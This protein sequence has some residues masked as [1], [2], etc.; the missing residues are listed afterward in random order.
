MALDV[1]PYH[2]MKVLVIEDLAEMRSSMKS[3]LGNMGVADI[4][5][6]NNGE[7]AL[8]KMGKEHYDIVFSDYELGRGKDGQQILED[9]GFSREVNE[10]NAS[11]GFVSENG[12]GVT[13]WTRNLFDEER[14]TTAFPGVAQAGSFNGYPSVPRTYG[15]SVRKQF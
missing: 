3:M 2:K 13:L 12:L 10:A 9:A 11:I 5:T 6:C 15:V 1:I 8:K 7:E 4:E 14:I